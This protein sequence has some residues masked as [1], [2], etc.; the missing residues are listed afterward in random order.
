MAKVAK[1]FADTRAYDV[2]S[3]E[4]DEP[5][6]FYPAHTMEQPEYV[7]LSSGTFYRPWDNATCLVSPLAFKSE[8]AAIADGSDVRG[9][10]TV[11]KLQV[12]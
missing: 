2:V 12:C 1:D 7:W 5:K 3:M 9:V 10:H 8:A 4:Y 6:V 11:T